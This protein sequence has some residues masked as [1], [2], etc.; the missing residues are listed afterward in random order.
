MTMTQTHGITAAAEVWRIDAQESSATLENGVYGSLEA[1]RLASAGMALR[2]G[3]GFVGSVLARRV[4]V[5][6]NELDGE[7]FERCEVA[8]DGNICSILGV[9]LF[10]ENKLAAVS[11]FMFRG[12]PGMVGAVE[13]WAGRRG[14]L[15]LCLTQAH[16]TGLDRFAAVSRYVNF[17]IGSGLPGLVWRDASPHLRTGLGKSPDFLRSTGAESA[18]LV[19]GL[20]FPIICGHQLQAVMLWLSSSGAPLARLHEV[21]TQAEAGGKTLMRMQAHYRN[22]NGQVLDPPVEDGTVPPLVQRCINTRRPVVFEHV[23]EM[24]LPEHYGLLSGGIAMPV[25]GNGSIRAVG[26]FAW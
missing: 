17:P 16:Y 26:V 13:L 7:V 19:T 6:L 4:P 22:A 15:E 5:M 12:D 21:W 9:P 18:G 24:G 2:A 1:L 3:E 20:G 14:R 25:L 23:S 8:R 11:V 10:D